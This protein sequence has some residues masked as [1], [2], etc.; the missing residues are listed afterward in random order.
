LYLEEGGTN[1]GVVTLRADSCF[2]GCSPSTQ[3]S[4]CPTNLNGPYEYPHLIIP[5]D[6]S[7]PDTPAGTSGNG[8]V[9]STISSIFNFDIPASD[10]GKTCSLIFL[11]PNQAQL[12]TSSY[13]FSGNGGIDFCQLTS[14]AST[15]TT[16][17]NTPNV[18]NDYGTT[19]VGPGN[20]YL[21]A[22]F[23]CPSGST[24]AF[25]MKASGDTS[26][27]YFQD[28]NPSPIGLYIRTC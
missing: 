2:S 3:P 10:A 19:I 20:S 13:T 6:S 21:I 9:T 11:F 17:D 27:N 14:P 25:E 12:T 16:Y 18:R 15:S 24:I 5:V 22:T 26:L 28:Y 1:C 7:K 23:P 8:I 4:A